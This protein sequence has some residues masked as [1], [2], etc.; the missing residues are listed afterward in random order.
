MVNNNK[1][2]NKKNGIFL[3]VLSNNKAHN[4]K[5]GIFFSGRKAQMR[6]VETI[7]ILMIFFILI[8]FGMIFY[9]QYQK[10][11]VKEQAK[12]MFVKQ[13][14]QITTKTLFLPELICSEGEAEAEDHCFD[15]LKLNTVG[16]LTSENL[17][18]YYYDVFGNSKI[19]VREI[20]PCSDDVCRE[21]T[22]YEKPAGEV[23]EGQVR[24]TQKTPFIVSLRDDTGGG[25]IDP[26][27][28]VGYV[29]V[30]LFK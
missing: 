25:I 6:I 22:I 18:E 3:S 30:E 14:I 28:S 29:E 17:E 11:A 15:I 4:K 20:Y 24:S 19:T 26:A 16:S 21:W 2:H 27:Y 12:E 1:A 10:A 13:A 23:V 8:F 7:A 9:I 5:N